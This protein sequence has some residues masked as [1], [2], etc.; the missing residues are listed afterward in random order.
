VATLLS[1]GPSQA[2]IL[3]PA[4]PSLPALDAPLRGAVSGLDRGL[5][6]ASR[7]LDPQRLLDLRLD[8]IARLVR[9]NRR[10]LDLDEAGEAVVRG[11]VLAVSPS[12]QALELARAAGFSVAETAAP[13]SLVPL[14][15]LT[16]PPGV[17]TREA[18]RTLRAVDPL[19]TY[20]FNHL[21]AE[22]ASERD[23]RAPA[24]ALPSNAEDGPLRIGLVDTGI[25]ANHPAFRGVR[26]E[27]RPFAAGGLVPAP[28]GTAVAS[29]A[30][31]RA[32]PS[33]IS[34]L[35][36]DVYGRGPTGG[37]A[38]AVLQG[39]S[40]LAV[41]GAPVINIS[42][43]GPPNAALAAAVSALRKRGVLV[44]APVGNDGPA[45]PPRYPASYP[46]VVAVTAVDA[47]G[48]VLLEAGRAR[49]LDFAAPG[50]GITAAKP[51]RG[52]ATMRGTS[53][54][55]PIVAARLARLAPVPTPEAATEAIERLGRAAKPGP[56]YGRGLVSAELRLASKP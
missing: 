15:T 35:V 40:W 22:S 29:L 34:L 32:P 49:H 20:D 9:A 21:Y 36:A 5:G 16:A 50:A 45:A 37:A 54:A 39:L 19:G 27:Q 17:D 48:K 8:R 33:G 30:L 44:V 41:Q 51:G 43:V 7:A 53:F 11:Q 14:V 28:H 38:V 56:D 47:R 2:Q 3:G 52:Y 26:I 10:V 42:L 12:P 4:T 13:D 23:G 55:S 31:G 25:D 46:E 18:V 24:A 1:G 6:E